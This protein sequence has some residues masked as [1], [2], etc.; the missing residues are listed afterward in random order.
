MLKVKSLDDLNKIRQAA[1][2]QNLH[3]GET[4]PTTIILDITTPAIAA[5]GLKTLKAIELFIET[6]E[7]QNVV[8]RQVGTLGM[9]S[10]EPI[11]QVKAGDQ[12]L[13]TYVRVDPTAA[14]RIMQEHVI[15]GRVVQEYLAE[16]A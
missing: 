14:E 10:W 3:V 2:T 12:P 1:S 11:L 8:V 4:A 15:A 16:P 7:L 6:H 5:G 13:M 9:D